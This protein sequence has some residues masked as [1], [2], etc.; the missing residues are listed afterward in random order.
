MTNVIERAPDPAL[1]TLLPG[2]DFADAFALAVPGKLNASEASR[3]VMGRTPSWAARLM[4]VRDCL[5]TPFGL[6]TSAQHVNPNVDRVGFFPV[7][8]AD[9]SHV[10]LGFPDRH[11]DFRVV[12]ATEP[13]HDETL[14]TVTTLVR[15]HNLLGR[16]YLACIKPFHRLI[17]PAM[18]RQ[19]REAGA[20][21]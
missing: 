10:V 19:A 7:V 13:R 18:L 6:K 15:T 1:R 5:V 20:A 21:P 14:I 17:V 4:A 12:V 11:L 8:E 3:R 9:D 16:V 2:A